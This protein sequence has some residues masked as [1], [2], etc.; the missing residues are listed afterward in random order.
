M[1]PNVQVVFVCCGE[2]IETFG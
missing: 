2:L 1:D